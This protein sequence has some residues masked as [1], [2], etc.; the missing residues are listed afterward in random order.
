MSTG[1]LQS[2]LGPFT[3][4]FKRKFI[5]GRD[6]LPFFGEA[7]QKENPTKVV[8]KLNDFEYIMFTW[9]RSEGIAYP[10]DDLILL[11]PEN[12]VEETNRRGLKFTS[13][14]LEEQIRGFSP[15]L[16]VLLRQHTLRADVC[17]EKNL[18]D[19]KLKEKL[20]AKMENVA[21]WQ[22]FLKDFL[23]KCADDQKKQEQKSE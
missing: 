8:Q 23:E 1:A 17:G 16:F 4:D 18:N 6:L 22:N 21:A 11:R 10:I 7:D 13:S 20:F 5:D 12:V 19:P 9:F 14:E 2:S 3:A 15:T